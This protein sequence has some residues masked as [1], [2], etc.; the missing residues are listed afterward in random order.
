M[1][2][3]TSFDSVFE[4]LQ[5]GVYIVTAEDG[6]AKAGC[7]A[8]WV[9]RSSFEPPMIATFIAPKRHTHDTIKRAG[10]FCVH[11]VGEHHVDLARGFGLKSSRDVDKFAG[12]ACTK[13]K[14]GA[15]ILKDACAY[16]DCQLAAEFEAGDHTCFVGRVLTA[17]RTSFDKPLLYFQEDFYP[18]EKEAAGQP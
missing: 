2:D 1:V 15:P 14:S 7:T 6:S 16:L 12:L 13:G 4:L 8:V 9:C 5:S 3:G 17:E 11:V 10:H 18:E